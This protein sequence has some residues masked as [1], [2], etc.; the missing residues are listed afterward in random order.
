MTRF[1]MPFRCGQCGEMNSCFKPAQLAGDVS[2]R[3]EKAMSLSD[4]GRTL[5]GTLPMARNRLVRPCSGG[6]ATVLAGPD[7]D[8]CQATTSAEREPKRQ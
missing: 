4:L 7:R 5:R 3:L 6:L 1:A 8:N 2:R